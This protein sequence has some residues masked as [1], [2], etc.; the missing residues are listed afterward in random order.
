MYVHVGK[1]IIHVGFD[2]IMGS[3]LRIYPLSI[4]WGYYI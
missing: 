4:W 1:I 2:T 3:A